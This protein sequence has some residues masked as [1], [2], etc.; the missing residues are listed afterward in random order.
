MQGGA[1]MPGLA[2]PR[3]PPGISA[4]VTHPRVFLRRAFYLCPVSSVQ[5]CR[6]AQLL[7][8]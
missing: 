4:S 3:R 2:F 5:P 7:G 1:Q 6:L 8:F